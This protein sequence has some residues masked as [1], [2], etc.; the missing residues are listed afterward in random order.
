MIKAIQEYNN[1][2][3]TKR[4]SKIDLNLTNFSTLN[5]KDLRHKNY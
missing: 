5:Y 4:E 1:S 2:K 3:L